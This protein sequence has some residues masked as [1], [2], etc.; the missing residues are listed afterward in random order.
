MEE[1]SLLDRSRDCT[2]HELAPLFTVYSGQSAGGE[3]Y[4][5]VHL[6]RD[7]YYRRDK[8]GFPASNGARPVRGSKAARTWNA[9]E[10]LEWFVNYLPDK[11]GAPK[12]NKNAVTHGGCVGLRAQREAVRGGVVQSAATP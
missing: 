2:A 9:D 7:W 6:V 12:G 3:R 8:T 1:T 11:G 10:A 4:V 5:D